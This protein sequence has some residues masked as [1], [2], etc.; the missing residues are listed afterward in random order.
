M[1]V[2]MPMKAMAA[3]LGLTTLMLAAGAQAAP[4]DGAKAFEKMDANGDGVVTTAE[5][6][7]QREAM[8]KR[9]DADGNGIITAEERDRAKARMER[10]R[11]RMQAKGQ[12]MWA[13]ADSNHDGQLTQAEFMAT[14]HGLLD[15]ADADHDGQLTRAEFDSFVAQRRSMAGK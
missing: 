8:F 12:D 7:A 5:A 4:H 11:E 2:K 13:Q 15:K 14:P 9:M 3:A 6:D 1:N 10:M